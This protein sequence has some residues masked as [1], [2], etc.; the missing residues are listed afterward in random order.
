MAADASQEEIPDAAEL[1]KKLEG[2]LDDLNLPLASRDTIRG[3]SEKQ[4]WD[5]I[6]SHDQSVAEAPDVGTTP[7]DYL[8]IIR[9][10][11]EASE[12]DVNDGIVVAL[13]NTSTVMFIR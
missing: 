6:L 3:M 4:Q 12:T 9:R 10:S 11:L 7:A 8:Q 1:A 5:M 13:I 2:V